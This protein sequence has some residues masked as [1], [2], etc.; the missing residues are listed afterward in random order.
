MIN[1]L[2]GTAS[3]ETGQ[4]FVTNNIGT[5]IKTYNG[6][7]D[8]SFNF[9]A[10]PSNYVP[11]YSALTE[12][13][14]DYLDG[15]A[16]N[17]TIDG[18]DGADT[19]IGGT[20]NDTFYV[21]NV[22]DTVSELAGDGT[23]TIRAFASYKLST[24]AEVETLRTAVQSGTVGVNLTGNNLAQSVF[25]N[26][27]ATSWL[28]SVAMTRSR[29]WTATT[30]STAERAMTCSWAARATISSFSTPSPAPRPTMT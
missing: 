2:G 27:G 13:G 22:A 6:I 17:D 26:D 14:I 19:M 15:G 24:T 1:S 4:T 7:T 30:G 12:T 9:T 23:D 28:P 21:D 20:G 5:F 25:G 8:E 18:G 16:G 3:V 11:F 10:T 29:G